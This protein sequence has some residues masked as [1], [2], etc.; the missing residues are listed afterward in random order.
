MPRDR[1]PSLLEILGE[2]VN[3]SAGLF[4]ALM[5]LMIISLPG[6][7]LILML[8]AVLLLAVAVVPAL[9]LGALL[10]PPLLLVRALRRRR[11]LSG[12]RGA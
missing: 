2:V 12:T 11:Q 10:T 4:V 9:V 3:L 6:V 5:P 7:F 1:N 8:P